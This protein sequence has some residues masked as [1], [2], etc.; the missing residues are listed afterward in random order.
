MDDWK[1]ICCAIDF[2]DPSLIAMQRGA[3]LAGRLEAELILLYVHEAHAASAEILLSRFEHALPEVESKM[4]TWQREAE[5]I[6]GRPTRSMILAGNAAAEIVRLSC[7]GSFDLLVLGT[8][9]R[10][11]LTRLV[12]GSVAE[13]VVREAECAVLVV[14]QSSADGDRREPSA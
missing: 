6:A 2:S 4:R 14:R 3:A 5:R 8:R 12:L 9:G 13:R 10:T 1:K 7:E 11:G